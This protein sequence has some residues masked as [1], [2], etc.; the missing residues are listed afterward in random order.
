LYPNPATEQITIGYYSFYNESAEIRI[1]NQVGSVIKQ[2]RQPMTVG[3]N[4]FTISLNELASGMYIMELNS[5]SGFAVKRFLK[6]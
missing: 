2:I 1:I 4:T 6:K 5:A 3:E